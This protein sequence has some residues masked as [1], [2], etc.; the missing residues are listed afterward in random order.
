MMQL[1]KHDQMIKHHE[2][3]VIDIAL[4]NPELWLRV[5]YHL[6]C[7]VTDQPSGESGQPLDPG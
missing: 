5:L 1:I 4:F 3:T 7:K 6:V 2:F